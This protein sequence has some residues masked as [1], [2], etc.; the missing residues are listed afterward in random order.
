MKLIF[1]LPIVR[2]GS[3]LLLVIR[4]WHHPCLGHLYKKCLPIRFWPAGCWGTN[5]RPS[6]GVSAILNLAGGVRG[7]KSSSEDD[8]E[9]SPDVICIRCRW[10]PT[11]TCR[12]FRANSAHVGTAS[13]A[14]CLRS[15]LSRAGGGLPRRALVF[16]V[17]SD[18]RKGGSVPKGYLGGHCIWCFIGNPHEPS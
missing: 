18:L 4:P 3:V 12:M 6:V 1:S 15:F 14:H 13:L 10:L 8:S 11:R 5:H 17:G 16:W 7:I 9:S 2:L